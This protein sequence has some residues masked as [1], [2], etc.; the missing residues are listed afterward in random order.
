MTSCSRTASRPGGRSTRPS[1]RWRNAD[2]WLYVLKAVGVSPPVVGQWEGVAMKRS[3]LS[4]LAL[5]VVLI[6]PS[7]FLLHPSEAYAAPVP[8]PKWAEKRSLESELALPPL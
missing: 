4:A 2:D 3:W 6:P 5:L 7:S 1:T 8:T